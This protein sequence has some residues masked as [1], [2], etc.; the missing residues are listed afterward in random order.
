[1]LEDLSLTPPDD[2][3]GDRAYKMQLAGTL[4]RRAVAL[5]LNVET[6]ETR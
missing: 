4:L 3:F 6:R 2:A 1:L 5:L